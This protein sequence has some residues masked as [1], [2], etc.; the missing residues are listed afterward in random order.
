[1]RQRVEG[2]DHGH[3]LVELKKEMR[4]ELNQLVKEVDQL[5][6]EKRLLEVGKAGVEK[7]IG[8]KMKK[9]EEKVHQSP[10]C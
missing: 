1:M 4:G 6:E 10:F 3:A 2:K 5:K 9:L 7:D 8:V